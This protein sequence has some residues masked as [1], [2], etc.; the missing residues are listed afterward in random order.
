[1][2]KH[3][4]SMGSRHIMDVRG[5]NPDDGPDTVKF[6]VL[7]ENKYKQKQQR[8]IIIDFPARTLKTFTDKKVRKAEIPFSSLRTVEKACVKDQHWVYAVLC[9]EKET[10]E[11]SILL[12]SQAESIALTNSIMRA[13][14][15]AQRDNKNDTERLQKEESKDLRSGKGR[16]IIQF[17][18]TQTNN[19]WQKQKRK[20]IVDFGNCRIKNLDLD[21]QLKTMH[22]FEDLKSIQRRF[23]KE[24]FRQLVEFKD[25]TSFDFS[26]QNRS[27]ASNFGDTLSR[28]MAMHQKKA[29]KMEKSLQNLTESCLKFEVIKTNK[30]ARKQKRELVIDFRRKQLR[31]YDMDGRLHRMFK[32]ECLKSV[33]K[34]FQ[35]GLYGIYIIFENRPRY[36][37]TFSSAEEANR[38]SQA[39]SKASDKVAKNSRIEPM[40]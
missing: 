25:Q 11:W 18:V 19:R 5:V 23:D 27:I 8:N 6:M 1:M 40:K 36:D 17:T 33:Q 12:T 4:K 9:E 24:N 29:K 14:A 28:A 39:L 3:T 38:M 35:N 32:F 26:F 34:K 2:S 15:L 7:K 37:L 10:K 20:I 31:N 22:R 16:G 13:I 30:W 21:G